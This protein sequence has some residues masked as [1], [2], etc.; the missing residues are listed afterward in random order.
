MLDASSSVIEFAPGG[1]KLDCSE[2]H[3]WPGRT[4][5]RWKCLDGSS[6]PSS[7]SAYS[8]ANGHPSIAS[9]R[10]S[11]VDHALGVYYVA[12]DW[13]PDTLV[14]SCDRRTPCR[15]TTRKKAT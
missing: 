6:K 13:I 8:L 10:D 3:L 12:L 2:S 1:V 9:L 5:V 11:G 4:S 15:H 14:S 7:A